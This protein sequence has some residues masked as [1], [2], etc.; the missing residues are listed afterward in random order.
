MSQICYI[1]WE[2]YTL[3]KVEG[4]WKFPWK[5]CNKYSQN[6][7][8]MDE[9]NIHKYIHW[10]TQNLNHAHEHMTRKYLV[11]FLDLT[12]LFWVVQGPQIMHYIP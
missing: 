5:F 8:Y 3:Y 1:C 12:P 7:V 2:K 6:L 4:G 11:K 9:T 10:T